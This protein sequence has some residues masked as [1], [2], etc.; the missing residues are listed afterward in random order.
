MPKMTNEERRS[1][2]RAMGLMSQIAFIVI[3]CVAMGLFIGYWLD[4]WLGTSPWMIIVFS[5]LGIGSAFKAMIDLS[6]KFSK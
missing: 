3:T 1:I 5:I 2:L 4:R 6:K